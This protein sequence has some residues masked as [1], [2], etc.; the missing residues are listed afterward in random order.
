MPTYLMPS[1]TTTNQQPQQPNMGNSNSPV[2]VD[3]ASTASNNSL[4]SGPQVLIKNINGKV[5]ITPV[6]GTG[7]TPVNTDEMLKKNNSTT[8]KSNNS[9]N[10]NHHHQ[11]TSAGNSNSAQQVNGKKSPPTQ[12]QVVRNHQMTNSSS[13][14][15]DPS[16][17][18]KSH[19]VPN[20]NGHVQKN[21]NSNTTT[22]GSNHDNT[23]NY[24]NLLNEN[25]HKYSFNTADGD[26]PGIYY[27]LK[28]FRRFFFNCGL[29]N[30]II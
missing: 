9:S 12:H 8:K 27:S 15:M 25:K 24:H 18:Q 22:H 10:N 28:I 17:I 26:D 1:T 13:S 29:N 30:C 2:S 16:L 14:V 3:S 21:R 4:K 19:S 20:V 7:A 6:P 23:N 11:H 5:T